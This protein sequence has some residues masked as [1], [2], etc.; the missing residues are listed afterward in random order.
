[1]PGQPAAFIEAVLRRPTMYTLSGSYGE[2][3]AFLEGYFSGLAIEALR[4]GRI[5]PWAAFGVDLRMR[6]PIGNRCVFQSFLDVH[7]TESISELLKAYLEFAEREGL[8]TLL[9]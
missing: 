6:Y 9:P 3:I 7:K 1:M 2:V 5:S 8:E 4:E